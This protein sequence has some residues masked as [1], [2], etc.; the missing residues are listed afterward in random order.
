MILEVRSPK[1]GGES[2]ESLRAGGASLQGPEKEQ[3]ITWQKGTLA[4]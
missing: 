3:N 1:S 4:F 2:V